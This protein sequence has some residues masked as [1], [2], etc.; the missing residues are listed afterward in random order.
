MRLPAAMIDGTC[1]ADFEGV[2][3]AFSK[4]FDQVW[5]V[6]TNGDF[7]SQSFTDNF[8]GMTAAAFRTDAGQLLTA[9]QCRS[10]E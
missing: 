10:T 4:N 5:T 3:E 2:R 6:D 8:N 9:R 1:A 7:V